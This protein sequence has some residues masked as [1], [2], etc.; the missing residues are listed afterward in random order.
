MSIIFDINGDKIPLEKATPNGNYPDEV[1]RR[2]HWKEAGEYLRDEKTD[3]DWHFCHVC[4]MDFK[5]KNGQS[6]TWWRPDGKWHDFIFRVCSV[7]CSKSMESEFVKRLGKCDGWSKKKA[8]T[9]FDQTVRIELSTFACEMEYNSDTNFNEM[10]EP[11]I[12]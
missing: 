10:Q 4:Q 3:K 5:W 2:A 1:H 7:A 9:N 11:N 6:I 12:K 8:Q